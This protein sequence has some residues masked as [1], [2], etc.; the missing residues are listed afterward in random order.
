MRGLILLRSKVALPTPT[1][2]PGIYDR[3]PEDAAFANQI[4][5]QLTQTLTRFGYCTVETPLIE[6]ADLFLTKSG[7]EAINRLFTFELYGRQLCLRSEFTASAAR[8][9][10]ERYQHASKPIRWQ[11]AGPVFRY[12]TPGRSHSRQFTMIGSEL[13]GPSGA[14]GDAETMGMAA[15]GLFALGLSK[16]SLRVGHVGL[17]AQVLD[18]FALDRR[19]RRFMLGH[20]ENLHRPDRGRAYVE[21]QFEQMVALPASPQPLSTSGEGLSRRTDFPSP[22]VEREGGEAN[23]AHALQ[24]LLES[25]NLG[26]TGTG[27]TNEDVARRLLTKQQR[28]NQR[29]EVSAALDFLERF[30]AIQGT[31]AEAF[32]AMDALVFDNRA[33]RETVRAFRSSVDLLFAY[34]L[35]AERVQVDMG[36]AR[37]LNYYTGIVFEIHAVDGGQL[38]GGGRYDDLI[39]V[40]GAAQDTPAIGFA[41][42]V[43]RIMEEMRRTDQLAGRAPDAVRALVVPID[44]VDNLVA[45][46]VANRLRAT[47]S[48]ELFTPPTRNVS[49]ALSYAER[50]AIQYVFIVG[51]AERTANTIT[52]RDMQ[53][54]TQA[55]HALADLPTLI[56]QIETEMAR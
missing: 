56:A 4:S 20:I 39:R 53:R 23:L 55:A 22:Q 29:G 2:P 5:A 31:P 51:E 21:A 49:Q 28:A 16:W 32:A 10:V 43:E 8:L 26:T 30:T 44:D 9:Y 18:Y 6:Y 24:L 47:W 12:E 19:T 52:V 40:L 35:P 13:I 33:I 50:H 41:Y 15:Q 45:A 37:G 7:D 54:R 11:F 25:A 3:G 42:G 46:Q 14:A 38:C 27:R 1:R 17:A 34:D 48:V 36:L